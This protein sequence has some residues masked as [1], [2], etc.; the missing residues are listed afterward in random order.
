MA[1]N[2]T[3]PNPRTMSDLC[4]CGAYADLIFPIPGLCAC[5]DAEQGSRLR[6][7]VH[8]ELSADASVC[9]CR[10]HVDSVNHICWQP[11]TNVMCTASTDKTLSLW[12]PRSGLCSHTFYGHSNSCSSVDF[13]PQVRA[14]MPISQST[15]PMLLNLIEAGFHG[16]WQCRF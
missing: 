15:I 4:Y 9:C 16:Q 5:H 7:L 1:H 14:P 11:G 12:D 8:S 2:H 6:C 3:T 13:S 10:G